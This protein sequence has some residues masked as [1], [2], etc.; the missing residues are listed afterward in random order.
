MQ[1]AGKATVERRKEESFLLYAISL[2]SLVLAENEN[3][4]MTYR[5]RQRVVHL[6]GKEDNESRVLL[7]KKISDLYTIRSKIVH[8]GYYQVTDA[9]LS[10]I[11]LYSKSCILKNAQQ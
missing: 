1:W 9:D 2:E 3:V 8:T 6:I 5:L 4:E 7:S 11:R 10:L